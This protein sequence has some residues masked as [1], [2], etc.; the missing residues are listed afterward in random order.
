MADEK[1]EKPPVDAALVEAVRRA[2]HE[3]LREDGYP[4]LIVERHDDSWLLGEIKQILADRQDSIRCRFSDDDAGMVLKALTGPGVTGRSAP[5]R[6]LRLWLKDAKRVVIADPYFMHGN[7]S[8]WGDLTDDEKKDRADAYADEV[9]QVLGPVAEVDVYH[10]PD[11]PKEL[12]TAMKRIAFEGRRVTPHETT[13]IHDR[14]WI[15]DGNDARVVGTSF[16]GIGSKLAFIIAL[17]EEDRTRFQ[18]ELRRIAASA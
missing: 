11:P 13:E 3:V 2:F 15:K 9:R 8:G 5:L 4:H 10:L 17:S 6:E 14:V 12:R 7:T 18:E 1:D 16:G